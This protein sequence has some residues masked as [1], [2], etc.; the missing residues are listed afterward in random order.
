MNI[1]PVATGE[2]SVLLA[3][4]LLCAAS[5]TRAQ[6]ARLRLDHLDRLAASAV[7]SVEITMNDLQVEFLKR[8]VSLSKTDQSKL[9]TLLSKLKGIYVRGYEFARDSEY[10]AADIEEIRAQL[11][12]PGWE[13]IVEVRK[14]N[15]GNGDNGGDS[16]DEVFFMPRNDEI[17]GFASISTA[18]RKICVIN[19]VGQMDMSE[20]ALLEKEF[21][22]TRCDGSNFGRRKRG[23][24]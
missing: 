22:I 7:E 18:P 1:K 23:A 3:L 11:R 15:G 19:I 13:R 2:S 21:H 10:S 16:G 9:K 4:L 20:M 5:S 8:V 24:K 12:S 6:D 14:R 17:A